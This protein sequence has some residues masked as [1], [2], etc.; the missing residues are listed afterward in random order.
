MLNLS[1]CPLVNLKTI[2][3][4]SAPKI[5]ISL[6]AKPKPPRSKPPH[7]GNNDNNDNGDNVNNVNNDVNNG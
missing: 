5:I 4:E 6:P 1:G 3:F 7:G 2:H